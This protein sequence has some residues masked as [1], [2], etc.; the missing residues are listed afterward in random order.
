MF[1][2]IIQFWFEEIDSK[3][4]WSVDSEFDQLI[5]SRFHSVML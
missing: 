3:K 2:D 5:H 1:Q 4:W